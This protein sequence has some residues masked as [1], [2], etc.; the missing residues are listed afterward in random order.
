MKPVMLTEQE[1][2]V[3]TIVFGNP[4]VTAG[5]LKVRL[6]LLQAIDTLQ[7][8]PGLKVAQVLPRRLTAGEARFD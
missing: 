5:S 1:D 4:P 3:F 7:M 6:G 8:S 2:D